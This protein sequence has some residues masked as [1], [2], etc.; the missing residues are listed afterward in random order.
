MSTPTRAARAAADDISRRADLMS[1]VSMR[2]QARHCARQLLDV[3]ELTYPRRYW[4][5]LARELRHLAIELDVQA[6][7]P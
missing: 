3:A 7:E 1:G 6:G 4:R 5:D 2:R